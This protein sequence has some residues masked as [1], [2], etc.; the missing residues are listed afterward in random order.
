VA[1]DAGLVTTFTATGGGCNPLS[2]TQLVTATGGAVCI[3]SADYPVIRTWPVAACE[4]VP[5]YGTLGGYACGQPDEPSGVP[6]PPPSAPVSVSLSPAS[7]TIGAS[8]TL[9]WDGGPSRSCTAS[10]AWSGPLAIAGSTSVGPPAVGSYAFTL[11]CDAGTAS[12]LL[13]VT[14]PS[15]VAITAFGSTP[16]PI[17]PGGAGSLRWTTTGMDAGSCKIRAGGKLLGSRLPTSS[18]GWRIP[19]TWLKN[20]TKFNL[21]CS[22]SGTN[23]SRSFTITVR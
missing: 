20:G 4:R 3:R 23:Y 9:T 22:S 18:S 8:S 14:D 6:P 15:A 5:G 19:G 21:V 12:T 2:Q 13:T 16:D 17:A 10:G 7:I 1:V 11:T